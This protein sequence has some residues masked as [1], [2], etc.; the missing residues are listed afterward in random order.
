MENYESELKT[1]YIRYLCDFWRQD[2]IRSFQ[3]E[4]E[5]E[6]KERIQAEVKNEIKDKKDPL[7]VYD[8]NTK[9]E[10]EINDLVKQYARKKKIPKYR[11]FFIKDSFQLQ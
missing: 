1:S 2:K 5:K 7:T 3:N 11:F 9:N 8:F 6:T 10:N 4:L